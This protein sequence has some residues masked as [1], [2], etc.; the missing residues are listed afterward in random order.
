MKPIFKGFVVG[1]LIVALAFTMSSSYDAYI[2]NQQ[3]ISDFNATLE[4]TRKEADEVLRLLCHVH[5]DAEVC[6][7]DEVTDVHCVNDPA[8]ENVIS[9]HVCNNE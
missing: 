2:L 9:E 6:Q 8:L 4:S 1:A 3:R 7:D 5:P